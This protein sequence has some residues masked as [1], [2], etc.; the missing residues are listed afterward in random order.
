MAILNNHHGFEFEVLVEELFHN[1]GYVSVC[2]AEQTD[3]DGQH[4]V[5]EEEING[6]R[7]AIIVKCQ[8]RGT[9]GQQVIQK[10]HS[11]I[12]T[13]DFNGPKRGIIVTNGRFT[14]SAQEYADRL[15]QN[16]NPHPIELLNGRDLREIADEVGLD[17]SQGRIEILREKSLHPYDPI[18]DVDLAVQKAFRDIE[19]IEAADLPAPNSLVTLRPVVIITADT[20]VVFETFMGITH[21]INDRTRFVVHAEHGHPKLADNDV[22][23]LVTENFHAAVEVDTERFTEV[24]DDVDERRFGQTKTEYK[25]W[26]V[27]RLQDHHNTMILYTGDNH[28]SYNKICEPNQSD[29]SVQ[30]IEPVYLPIIRNIIELQG[31][32]YPYEYYAAGSSQV[33]SEDGIHRCVHCDTSGVEET[34]TYCPNCGAIACDSHIRTER[35]EGEPVCTNC[36]V[37]ERF[38]LKTKYFYDEKNLDAFHEKYAEMPLHKKAVENKRLVVGSIVAVLLIFV[39]LLVVDGII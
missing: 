28:A 17:I 9:I 21:Q 4:L 31:Y 33:T 20:N 13:F 37:A 18:E 29:I 16:G 3:N 34:Y 35:L 24:F 5:M 22:A 23:T 7:R 25:E 26:A 38:A 8:H 36:A 27:D 15:Q 12:A 6:T 2:Q 11:A 19:N 14:N 39:G 10:L 1:L 32:S 30:S